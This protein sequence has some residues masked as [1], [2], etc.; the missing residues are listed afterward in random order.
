MSQRAKTRS[1]QAQ[2]GR[3]PA[4][5]GQKSAL[6]P[7]PKSPTRATNPR[8]FYDV[9]QYAIITDP[10]HHIL[11]LQLPAKYDEGT[12]NTWTLP[13]GKLEPTDNPHTGLEREIAE[14]TGLAALV[15][16][17]VTVARWSTR[18]SKKLA[19]FYRASVATAAPRPTLSAEHQ[20]HAWVT[21]AELTNFPFHRSDMVDVIKNL[22]L[23]KE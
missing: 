20:R 16:G 14:E 13:G 10:N 17:P 15:S 2:R 22:N 8:W 23:T 19:I 4:K 12:A 11:I 3:K 1:R 9:R 21:V 18:S 6:K 7:A 5:T